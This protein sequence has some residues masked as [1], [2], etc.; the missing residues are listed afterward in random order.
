MV[1]WIK[2]PLG[3]EV[4]L[5]ALGPGGIVL[6]GDPAPPRKGAQQAPIFRPTALARST[7]S[8]TAELLFLEATSLILLKI[9][10]PL[11]FTPPPPHEI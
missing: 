3:T 10:S 9:N 7:I 6:N 8:A 1:G 2:M 4:G 5:G 11:N